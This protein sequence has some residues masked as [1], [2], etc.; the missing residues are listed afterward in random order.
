M[1]TDGE[2]ILMVCSITMDTH[3]LLCYNMP[4]SHM[5]VDGVQRGREEQ[6]LPLAIVRLSLT[7][8]RGL[9][10]YERSIYIIMSYHLIRHT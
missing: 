8:N 3:Y 4:L 5:D 9:E 1:R 10:E 2:H 7:R 6:V